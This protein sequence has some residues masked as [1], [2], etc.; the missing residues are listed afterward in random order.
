MFSKQDNKPPSGYVRMVAGVLLLGVAF[1]PQ[2]SPAA[3]VNELVAKAK[4]EGV[5]NATVTSS[6]TGKTTQQLAAAFKK[7]FGLDIEITLTPV[8]DTENYPKAIAETRTGVVPTY[9]AMEGSET[10]NLALMRVGG[11]QKIDDWESLAGGI[12]SY[13]RSGK[14]H[15]DQLSPAVLN[16]FAFAYLTRIKALIYN[17]R[18]ISIKDLPRTHAELADPKYKG[19]WTQPPWTTHWEPGP[20]VFPDIGKEKWLEIVRNAGKNAGTVLPEN[21]GVQRVLLGEYAFTPANTYY[22]FQ[23]KAKDPQAPIEITYFKDYNLMTSSYYIVR[24]GARRPAGATLFSFWMAT[25]E[26]KAI[27]QP[28][29]FVTQFMWGESELDKKVRQ[30][31]HDSGAKLVDFISTE[32][33]RDLL[34]WYGTEEG[35]KYTQSMGKAIRGE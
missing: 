27:W 24:K 2:I 11:I 8:G 5:L 32:K 12:N 26:A 13:V 35:V 14:A 4:Q 23:A 31:I 3:T 22:A 25:P 16:G 29:I 21:P 33:G 6:L 15:A 30:L 19:K 34:A 28:A 17:P 10:H 1:V 7:R 18:L 20:M 9:D